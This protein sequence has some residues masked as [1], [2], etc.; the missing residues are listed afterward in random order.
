M[1]FNDWMWAD[2]NHTNGKSQT[3]SRRAAFWLHDFVNEFR[4]ENFQIIGSIG[5]WQNQ[6]L[7]VLYKIPAGLTLDQIENKWAKI[8]SDWVE[9]H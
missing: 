9:A 7:E 2:F 3:D 6:R 8:I 5:E 1:K 4:I